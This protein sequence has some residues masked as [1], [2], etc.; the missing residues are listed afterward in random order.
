MPRKVASWP[1]RKI[2][3]LFWLVRSTFFTVNRP[4]GPYYRITPTDRPLEEILGE[5]FFT[6]RWE[7]SYKYRGE[8]LNMRRCFY[9]PD[10]FRWYQFHIRGWKFD[11]GMCDLQ[12]HTEL[13]PSSYP[14]K[15]LNGV[16][17]DREEGMR[18]LRELLEDEGIEYEL[19]EYES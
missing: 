15:H 13:E 3:E 12:A 5:R 7:F 16:R 14:K 1:W 9:K 10:S 4:D 17:L 19:V 11:N 8:T 18:K 6:N 2:L